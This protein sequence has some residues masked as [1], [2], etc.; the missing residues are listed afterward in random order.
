MRGV[1]IHGQP[2]KLMWINLSF[3]FLTKIDAEILN[4]PML[5]TLLLHGNYISE[6]EEVKKLQNLG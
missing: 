5:K 2:E 3:N 1:L 4:F 6:M